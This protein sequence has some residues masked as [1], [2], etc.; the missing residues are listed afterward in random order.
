MVNCG[1]I[2]GAK[3]QL[4]TDIGSTIPVRISLSTTRVC[5]CRGKEKIISVIGPSVWWK[6][7]LTTIVSKKILIVE[8]FLAI[9]FFVHKPGGCRHKILPHS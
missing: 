5:S 9:I 2:S 8:K 4:T 7:E 3:S 6:L 1:V